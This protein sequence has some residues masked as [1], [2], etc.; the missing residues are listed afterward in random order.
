M[1]LIHDQWVLIII[2]K[3]PRFLGSLASSNG[4]Y[5]RLK[6]DNFFLFLWFV[7]LGPLELILVWQCHNA[8]VW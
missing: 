6:S 3:N 7:P 4:K 8:M 5:M 1:S 2:S